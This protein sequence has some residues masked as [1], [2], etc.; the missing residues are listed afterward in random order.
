MNRFVLLAALLA[1]P[2]TAHAGGLIDTTDAEKQL[3]D[4]QKDAKKQVDAETDKHSVKVGGSEKKSGKKSSGK[5][6]SSTTASSAS[7]K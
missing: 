5:K 7:S 3:R 1:L 4:A 6:K 2:A